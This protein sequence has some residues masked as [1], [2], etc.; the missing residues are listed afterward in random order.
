MPEWTQMSGPRT[1]L[2]SFGAVIAGFACILRFGLGA[3]G[4][5]DAFVASVLVVLAAIDL[6]RRILPNVIVLPS[7]VVVYAAQMA[8]FPQHALGWTIA[9]VGCALF[10]FVTLLVYP[11]GLGMGDVKLGLLLGAAL[12]AA[13]VAALFV[14]LLASAIVGVGMLLKE[15]AGA[16]K[17]AI[18]LGP[19]LAA[20]ALLILYFG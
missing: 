11:A 15:G 4:L 13:V 9:A 5:I 3:R 17:K 14:G 16:R 7:A 6:E 1:A 20:G 10:F 19:F 18:P 12:G 8:F 2:V